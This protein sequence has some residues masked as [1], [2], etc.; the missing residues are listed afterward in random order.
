MLP[1]LLLDVYAALLGLIAGSYLNVVIHRLPRGLSTVLPR[2]A[3]PACGV[4]IRARDNLPLLSYLLLR[5]RCRAC[6]API[7]WRYPLVEAA[8][9]ALFVGCAERFGLSL[10]AA[11]AALFCCLMIAL[12]LIDLEHLLLPD[13]LTLPGIAVGLLLQPWLPWGGL[14]P[15]LLGALLGAGVLLALYGAWYLLRREEGMGLGDVEMLAL[16]GAFLGWQATLV[17][18]FFASLLGAAT[19]LALMWRGGLG[20][21]SKL[22]FGSFLAVAGLIAL[23]A[24]PEIASWYGGLLGHGGSG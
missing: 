6:G 11:A 21:K 4:P 13:R 24:G 12:G 5:G 2:S 22:P 19:G 20:M 1:H 10:A 9:A 16:V 17:T 15:A 7:A 18:L 14:R 3:C 23:F 8:T